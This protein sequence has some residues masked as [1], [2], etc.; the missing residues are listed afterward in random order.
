MPNAVYSGIDSGI[1][2][3][4]PLDSVVPCNLNCLEFESE[5]QGVTHQ[6]PHIL[7]DRSV[8]LEGSRHGMTALQETFIECLEEIDALFPIIMGLD[9]DSAVTPHT[10]ASFT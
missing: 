9:L 7:L 4:C 3:S 8:D 10:L 1:D 5:I 6:K 2:R